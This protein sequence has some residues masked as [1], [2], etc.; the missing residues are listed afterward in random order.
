MRS[1]LSRER[2]DE[3]LPIG[4]QMPW[5]LLECEHQVNPKGMPAEKLGMEGDRHAGEASKLQSV[6]S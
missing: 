4:S 5:E 6:K 3:H 1:I 2:K